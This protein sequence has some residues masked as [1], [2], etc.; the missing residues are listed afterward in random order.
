MECFPNCLYR[1]SW[2]IPI[3]ADIR[4]ANVSAPIPEKQKVGYKRL[5][6]LISRHFPKEHRLFRVLH[7]LQTSFRTHTKFLKEIKINH[8]ITTQSLTACSI[9]LY[10]FMYFMQKQDHNEYYNF[11]SCFLHDLFLGFSFKSF[12]KN[13]SKVGVNGS[14]LL[15][16]MNG[17]YLNVF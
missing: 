17:P 8:N 2:K 1:V 9:F 13:F 14:T 7:I 5:D 3:L 16:H 12:I 4:R 6:L 15:Y 10:P 11:V